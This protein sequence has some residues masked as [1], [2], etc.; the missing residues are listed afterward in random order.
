[1]SNREELIKKGLI[2]EKLGEIKQL[3]LQIDNSIKTINQ[4]LFFFDGVDSLEIDA[5]KA[6]FEQL[7][8]NIKKYK[9][10]SKEIKNLD[11]NTYIP[12]SPA[13]F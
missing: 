5:A 1:M 12:R 6:E 3:L 10:L 11:S 7:D 4:N 8:Q 2:Q 9:T 13:E